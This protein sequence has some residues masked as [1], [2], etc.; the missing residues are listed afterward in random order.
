MEWSRE[1]F[2]VTAAAFTVLFCIVGMALWGLPFYYDFMV[3]QFG[4]SRG[5]VTSGNALSKLVVGPL[6]GFFAGWM[7][8]RFGPRRLMLAG[9]LMA[10][11]ALIGLGSISTLGMFYFF[12]MLNALG[13]VCGG[14]LPSQ[15]LLSRWFERSRGKAMGFAYLGIGLGGAAVPWISHT[16]VQH[17]GWQ[18]ALRTL[19]LLILVI[20]L[21]AAL[22]AKEPPHAKKST[23]SPGFADA[24]DAFTTIPFF[25]LTLGSM[26][27]IAAV[28]GTQQN[29]KL[30]LSLDLHF[31][32]SQ[33]ARIL[34]LVLAFSIVGR[35]LM[36]WLADRFSK[37]YVMVLIYMLVAAAIPLLF[38]GRS[39]SAIYIFAVVFGIGLGG[40]YMIVP[41][42]TA[43]IFGVQLL[44]RLLGVILTAG[45]VAE[46]L[47]PWLVGRLRDS[48]GSYS[49]GFLVLI[50][51]GLLGAASAAMLP[52][53]K[54]PA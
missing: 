17:F 36:G 41:L 11:A 52:K 49:A 16:L 48:T 12:Y 32:Q 21:P 6:F 38:A 28:S 39:S 37:K 9:I 23:V 25:L 18:A 50:G 10:G 24:R 4:W 19:G 22:L 47:S 2:Q 34:S 45:S 1:S 20:A 46:A 13:Y 7:V 43:E 42:M 44:G 51:M 35:L 26:F 29:L 27:S 5:Q 3:Q 14:P 53:G 30:F 15:V 31:A 33:A 54:K 40:D 8:D